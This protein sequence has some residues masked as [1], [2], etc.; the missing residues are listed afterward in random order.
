[1]TIDFNGKAW[2]MIDAAQT[3]LLASHVNPDGDAIGSISALAEALEAMGK[4]V[5]M[6]LP[7]MSNGRYRCVPATERM[8]V[9]GSDLNPQDAARISA[10]HDVMIL[11]DVST[12]E[13]LR[14][15][16]EQIK[17]HKGRLVVIDH[18][19]S[20]DDLGQVEL[21]DEQAA[22]AG[23]IVQQLLE[24]RHLHISPSI[25][26]SLLVA[27]ASDTGWMRYPSVTPE[28]FRRVARLQQ[29]G[30]DPTLVYQQLF[31]CDSGGKIRLMGEAMAALRLSD[32]GRVAD[33]R[34]TQDMFSRTGTTM[35]DS[36]NIIDECS[37]I[38]GVQVSLLLV[39]VDADHSRASLRSREHS[40]DV[41]RIAAQFNGG[42][43]ARAA[44]CRIALPLE[45]ARAQLLDAVHKALSG[46]ATV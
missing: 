46:D 2:Q 32:D 5:T 37:R 34:L 11:V 7:T 12:W 1:M 44:G 14:G 30:A 33:L 6:V 20:R 42:G 15:L 27:I 21:V 24:A 28:T 26:S 35:R 45:K 22:A 23:E 36:E 8:I 31:Q 10:L 13:Q 19:R 39:E 18:H 43:H 29:A 40:I 3:V 9:L 38:Q 4:T 25:A 41:D 17:A 16:H